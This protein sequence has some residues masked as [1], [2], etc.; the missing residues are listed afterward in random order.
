MVI[1]R[2]VPRLLTA[3]RVFREEGVGGL[4]AMVRQRSALQLKFFSARKIESVYLDGCTFSLKHV[5]NTPMKLALLEGTYEGFERQAV[6]Q[7]VNQEQPVIELGGCIGVVACITNRRLKRPRLHVVVE[8]NPHA[9]PLLEENRR[10]N[11]CEFEILNA[12]IA[13]GQSSVTFS[14]VTDWWGNSLERKDRGTTVTVCTIS[15][16][17]IVRER[18]FDSFTLICDIEGHEYDLLL[19]EAYV[20]QHAETII[21]ETHARLIGEPRTSEILDRLE[22]LGFRVVDQESFV[23]VM[24]RSAI[25]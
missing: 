4:L 25:S 9:I 16:G 18:K 10:R 19:N 8:A 22:K 1:S 15:L 7:Y 2:S 12:A 5:P 14:P 20:L 11:H 17:D 24:K 3:L 23:V 21:L 6:L 13:Y